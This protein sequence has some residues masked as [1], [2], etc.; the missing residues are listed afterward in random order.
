MTAPRDEA[1]PHMCSSALV[2]QGGLAQY[3]YRMRGSATAGTP[4]WH[5][6]SI[7]TANPRGAIYGTIVAS[8]VIAVGRTC[9]RLAR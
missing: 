7:I 2:T 1:A 6:L 4:Q 3:R 8:A 9:V 5:R